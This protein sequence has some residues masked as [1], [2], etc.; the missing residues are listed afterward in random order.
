MAK[1]KRLINMGLPVTACNMRCEYC[2]VSQ[3]G[4]NN[5]SELGQLDYP[6]EHIQR[7]LTQKRLGGVCHISICGNGETLLP[8]YAMDLIVKMLENGHFVSIATNGTPSKR[9]E[10]LCAL[11]EEYRKRLFIKFSFHYLELKRLH[12]LDTFFYNIRMARGSGCSF[13]LELGADDAYIPQLEEIRDVC[14][15]ELGADCHVIELRQQRDEFARLTQKQPEERQA[16]WGNFHS[17]LFDFQQQEWGKKRCEFCYAGDWL[18]Q[19][20][21]RTGWTYPC[22]IGGNDIQNIFENPDEPIRPIAIGE[23]CP[24]AHCYPAFVLLTSGVIPEL[25]A[26]TYGE[27]R[28]RKAADGQT[29]LRPAVAE[30]FSSKFIDCNKEY[31]QGKKQYINALMALEYKNRDRRILTEE[32]AAAVE[33]TLLAKGIGTVAIWGASM[34]TDWLIALL[35]QT[36]IQVKYFVDPETDDS[37][38]V[39]SRLRNWGQGFVSSSVPRMLSRFDRLAHVDAM[40][41]TNYSRFNSERA[42]IPPVYDHLL[43]ITELAD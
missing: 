28:D 20:D 4:W 37:S 40:I 1:I 23:N 27:M 9:I 41:V 34:Y 18:M 38:S 17:P 10:A 32:A 42:K 7:C 30:F 8:D 43:S 21:A 39:M 14:Q 19:L 26:P 3:A 25:D 15:R 12:L 5:T 22:Y 36:N 33:K 24:W 6:P 11:P 2:H 29:W 31:P 35:L 16:A 13:T